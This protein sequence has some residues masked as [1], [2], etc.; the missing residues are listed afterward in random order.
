MI[1]ET[2]SAIIV[3]DLRI[4]GWQLDNEPAVQFDFNPKGLN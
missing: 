2:C 4:V 3:S 1:E